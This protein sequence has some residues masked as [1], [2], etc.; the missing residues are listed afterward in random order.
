MEQWRT[1]DKGFEKK[2]LK[3]VSR[4]GQGKEEIDRRVQ[5]ILERV[6]RQGDKALIFFTKKYDGVSLSLDGITAHRPEVRAAARKVGKRELK[7]LKRAAERIETFH[8]KTN[9]EGL[10]T[11]GK[12]GELVGYLVRPLEKV[13]LYVPGGKASYPSTVLMNAMPAKLAG[14]GQIIVCTPPRL[15]GGLDPFVAAAAEIVGIETIVK[16][17]GAQAIAAMTYGTASVPKVDK[18]VG[19]GNVFVTTAK[20]L[21]YGQVG[22][23][24]LAGPS[25]ILIIADG[26]ATPSFLAADLLSQAEHDEMAWPVL[27]TPSEGLATRVKAEVARGLSA[28]PTA[29]VAREA[30]KKNGVTV[31][32]TDLDEAVGLAN[33]LAFEHLVLAVAR[34]WE[35]L[36]RIKNAGAVFMGE[37]SP[38][39]VG[40]YLAGPNH[41]LPTGGTARFFS[42]VSVLDFVKKISVISFG[43]DSLARVRSD[44]ELLAR[45]EGLEAH[46][47]AVEARF[48]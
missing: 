42:G 11:T 46:A 35:L 34:P 3:L 15:K 13:G 28:L 36:P 14:V 17:G 4:G 27:L 31:I 26:E 20:R 16:V 37:Y 8:A 29:A 39:A 5:N 23:D 48:S 43:R 10:L 32:T 9:L 41:T 19:P 33:Q 45:M 7:S 21:V 2:F 30:I 22:I 40:D 44:V 24:L 38:E 12:D 18:I 47:R 1:R 25:E 6:K